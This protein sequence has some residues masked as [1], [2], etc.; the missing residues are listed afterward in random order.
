M[1]WTLS[2]KKPAHK[3]INRCSR[4]KKIW[5]KIETILN[6]DFIVAQNYWWQIFNETSILSNRTTSESVAD[7]ETYTSEEVWASIL[8]QNKWL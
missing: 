1:P 7:G 2:H 8:S 5:I 3:Q 4:R 6:S